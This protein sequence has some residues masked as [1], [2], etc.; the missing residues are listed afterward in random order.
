MKLIEDI[1][2]ELPIKTASADADHVLDLRKV[3]KQFGTDPAVN[4]LVDVGLVLRRGQWLSITGPSGA[5]KST[6]L[7]VIGCLDRPSDGQ[8][9]FEG[10][11]TTKLSE[12]ERAGLRSQRIGFVFQ[13]FHLL[14]YR[15][16]LE[17][18][19]LAEVYRQQTRKGRRERAM[20]E[21]GRVGLAHRAD[22]PPSKLSGGECQRVAI[23]R[24]LMG[25]P[26]LL[27]CDEPTGNLD[28]KNSE[29]ILEL[30]AQLNKEGMTIVVVTHDE[31]VASRGSRRVTMKDGALFAGSEPAPPPQAGHARSA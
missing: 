31:N 26:G 16:V 13:A 18:V 11:E 2:P 25:S 28:S 5:G 12:D 7:N 14:P 22:F 10:I 3:C 8:Y 15:S 21:I 9:L 24:A 27:L 17:N 23:A 29:L 1:R 6:L 20:H 19:M 4:A 30:L